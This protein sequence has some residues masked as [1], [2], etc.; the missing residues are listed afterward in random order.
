MATVEDVKKYWDDRPCNI[1]HSQ[2]EPGTREFFAEQEEKKY[3]VEPHIPRL[4]EYE[5]WVG[6]KVLEIGCGLGADTIN[7]ARAGAIVTA[8]DLSE[9]SLELA[10]KR[11]EIFNLSDRITFYQANVEELDSVVPIEH[12]D[13][14]YSFGVLHHTPNP[15]R[16]IICLAKY[17]SPETQ[18]RI[19]LYHKWSWKVLWI[20]LKYGKGAFW[21]ASELVARYS[22]AQ[23]GCPQTYIYSKKSAAKL[24][25][26]LTITDIWV[27]HIFPYSI[28]EYRENIYKKR[29][30]F[31]W[32]PLGLFS[33]L[34]IKFGWH[35]CI[36]SEIIY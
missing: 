34:E 1:K 35:L 20:I 28:K 18:M 30:Y 15:R 29:W 23:E 27:D 36:T 31:R 17:M 8:V 13:L 2:K 22:E 3:F 11:A 33:L 19:M 14:I 6:K 5:M 25:D 21:K 16:A 9:K 4:A 10:K 32:M 12:Y 7:F 26:G 24:L